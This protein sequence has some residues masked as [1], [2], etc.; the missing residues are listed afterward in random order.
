MPGLDGMGNRLTW[1]SPYEDYAGHPRSA[2]THATV[3]RLAREN[4]VPL[5][6]SLAQLNYWHA[7]RL[8]EAGIKAMD[9]RGR[10]QEGMV[11]D[12]TVFDPETVTE[13]ATYSKGKSGLASTGIS[14]VLVN[15]VVVVSDRKV[16]KDINPGQPIRFQVEEETR[17]EPCSKEQRLS[18]F[19]IDTGGVRPTLVDDITDDAATL[20]TPRDNPPRPETPVQIANADKWFGNAAI[21]R[22]S[23]ELDTHFH[24]DGH[25]H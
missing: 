6:F 13:N 14:Y 18:T 8:G 21:Q 2:G 20:L 1:D 12:I 10:V 7:M 17:F 19:T 15:G 11:A 4:N 24:G 3:L 9:V 16:L 5:M 22:F 23:K 25:N